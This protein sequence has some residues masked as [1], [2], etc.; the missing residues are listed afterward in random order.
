MTTR[1]LLA[2][3]LLPA[4]PALAEVYRWVDEQGAVHFSDEAPTASAE[5]M[6]LKSPGVV[7]LPT[8]AQEDA[9]GE[10][11]APEA[12]GAAQGAAY[13]ALEVTA[14]S[15]GEILYQTLP[16]VNVAFELSPALRAGEDHQ[17]VIM[18]DGQAVAETRDS[19]ATI[20]DVL[21]GPH[22]VSVQ[23]LDA[24]RRSLIGSP[25]V[26]FFVRRRSAIAGSDPP[27][28]NSPAVAAPAF[29]RRP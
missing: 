8:P 13:E 24:E 17:V 20:A 22:T 21:P 11:A 27:G 5:P 16:V 3:V 9:G 23:V 29:P 14:P 1:L 15:E 10:D 18:L 25:P 19:G 12:A 6:R 7:S 2:L 26:S 4:T 28:A